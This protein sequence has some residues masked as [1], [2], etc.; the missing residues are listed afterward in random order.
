VQDKVKKQQKEWVHPDNIKPLEKQ[1]SAQV[2]DDVMSNH[3]DQENDGWDQDEDSK[4]DD[5][6]EEQWPENNPYEYGWPTGNQIED[7]ASVMV[8]DSQIDVSDVSKNLSYNKT[9]IRIYS[10]QQLL[11]E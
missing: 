6:D 11:D 9:Q 3:Q 2:G 7:I 1:K 8:P 4:Q 5:W 10:L